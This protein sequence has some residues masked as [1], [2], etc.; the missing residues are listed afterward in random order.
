MNKEEAIK[1]L[2]LQRNRVGQKV[3]DLQ[4]RKRRY[5]LNERQR[6]SLRKLTMKRDS[7]TKQLN[8]LDK[9]V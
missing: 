2:R 7:L 1:N 9:K 3:F 4:V 8:A 5:G 6:Q